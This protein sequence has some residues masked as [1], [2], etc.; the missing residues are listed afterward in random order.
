MIDIKIHNNDE[1]DILLRYTNYQTLIGFDRYDSV[2]SLS[3]KNLT[4]EKYNQF[5]WWDAEIFNLP[6]VISTFPNAAKHCLE[7]RY[8]CLD[9]ARK[10]QYYICICDCGKEKSVWKYDLLAGKIKSCGCLLR[11]TSSI[12]CKKRNYKHQITL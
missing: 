8:R 5:V 10:N 4:A 11:E 3:A 9:E 12:R 1:L 6:I 2:H 7:Y